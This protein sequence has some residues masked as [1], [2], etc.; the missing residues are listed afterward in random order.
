MRPWLL[1]LALLWPLSPALA[2]ET[3]PVK[4]AMTPE[5]L[6]AMERVGGAA[7]S[8]DG[9]WAV[10]S[11]SVFS[12][13]SNK[14]NADLWLVPTDG[15]QPPRR[16][17]WNE[18]S[19][20]SPTWSP[21]GRRIA[22]V[23]KRGETPP[24]LYLLPLDGGGEAEPVTDLPVG[25]A[26]PRWFPDGKRIGFLATTWPDANDDWKLVKERLDKAKDEKTDAKISESRLLR[27]WDAYKTDG[28]VSHLFVLDLETRKVRD[29]TPGS[30]LV[31]AFDDVGD[32]DLAPDGREAALTANATAA[33]YRTLDTDVFTLAIAEDGAPGPMVN[34]TKGP[35]ALDEGRARYSPDGRFLVY[36][37]SRRENV[38]SDF[39]HLVRRDRATGESRELAPDWDAQAA[40]WTFSPD[41]QGLYFVAEEKGRQHLF[42]LAIDG[43]EPE[44]LA[45]GGVLSALAVGGTGSGR[46]VLRQES[47]TRPPRLVSYDSA[48][49]L[50]TLADPNEKR[51]AELDL[52]RV[53]EATF[54]GAG[55]APVHLFVVL[56]PGFDPARRWPLLHF[57]HGG[58]HGAF[59]DEFH[60]RWNAALAASR[61]HVV[62]MVNFH[63]STGYG[64]A[65]ADAI[66]GAHGDK[67]FA[68]VMAAT[69]HVL[70]R[71]YVDDQR[72]AAAGGSYGGY[73]VA[74][75]LG[76]TD[77]FAALIDHA[78]V[79]D[80][81][82]QFAS[83]ATWGREV[84]Y[85]ATPWTDPDRID[86]Y[87]PSRFA[88]R[89]T[90]PTLILHGEK[91]YRVP[92]TQGINLYGV[93]Q[94]KGV[95]SRIVIFPNE[96]HWVLKPKAALLW[97]QEV[98]AW[99][100]R[101]APAGGK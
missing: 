71:G 23:S 54:A 1:T 81:M 52:G 99:L 16:L 83:D 2:A 30:D 44:R 75:I 38:P 34:L 45:E 64:Q 73:L 31:L 76:H 87:S 74:W 55:G 14:S 6:W 84:S 29:L 93:L 101:Y 28:T 94:A 7:V 36:G 32:W 98:F 78:G 57:I 96:N 92:V 95:P 82:A 79:Y 53:E 13:E 59:R 80:L 97:W 89:F 61:G 4:R 50:V 15:S 19:D 10:Y 22:F 24:Q 63:G 48:A 33:P 77:R 56:P 85:G 67:P 90:T 25:P 8:P 51:L 21:D 68:D 86:L 42:R 46:L 43:G 35:L 60:F 72:L 37:R 91:D 41:G 20:G 27:F 11:L 62:A 88:S 5:D 40:D 3:P 26:V 65:F 58:P 100:E 9:R 47:I 70:A 17:T 66:Q 18:G 39:S 69:D 49:G 12:V